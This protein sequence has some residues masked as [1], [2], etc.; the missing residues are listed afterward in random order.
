[1][2][3]V[4]FCTETLYRFA[5]TQTRYVVASVVSHTYTYTHTHTKQVPLWHMQT[6]LLQLTSQE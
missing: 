6:G 1:M 4:K 2:P 3:T 5:W